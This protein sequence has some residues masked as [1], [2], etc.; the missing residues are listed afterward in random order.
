MQR[1]QQNEDDAW[2]L[3]LEDDKQ[4]EL[5]EQMTQELNAASLSSAHRPAPN[6]K[7]SAGSSLWSYFS[8]RS[9]ENVT[10]PSSAAS[11]STVRPPPSASTSTPPRHNKPKHARAQTSPAGASFAAT[12]AASQGPSP[13]LSRARSE[14]AGDEA[15]PRQ[16]TSSST[17]SSDG[18]HA[19]ANN[20]WVHIDSH[21]DASS[22]LRGKAVALL[23]REEMEAAVRLNVTD[24]LTGQCTASSILLLTAF[25]WTLIKCSQI[26]HPQYDDCVCLIKTRSTTAVLQQSRSP[27][28]PTAS[29]MAGF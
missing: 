14:T 24:I 29:R 13:M 22:A 27:F 20:T 23:S 1:S 15:V 8:R 6:R 18:N 11:G 2:S 17:S 9:S 16:S 19:P 7:A 5:V 12:P 3:S 4:S 26:P 28:H 25:L 10:L 21:A